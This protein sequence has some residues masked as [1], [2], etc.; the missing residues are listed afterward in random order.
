VTISERKGGVMGKSSDKKL[1]T[2]TEEQYLKSN[3]FHMITPEAREIIKILFEEIRPLDMDYVITLRGR[4]E[5]A[6]RYPYKENK[7]YN[8]VTVWPREKWIRVRVYNRV[9]AKCDD[10]KV[11]RKLLPEIK[12]K[13][14]EVISSIN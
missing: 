14:Q 13:Y 3:H 2:C 7:P 5:I 12:D 4:L 9:I 8:I 11:I 10:A 1:K 6:I